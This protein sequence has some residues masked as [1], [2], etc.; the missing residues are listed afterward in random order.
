MQRYLSLFFMLLGINGLSAQSFR[1]VSTG[2][3]YSQQTFFQLGDEEVT[4]LA[5]ETWDLAFT[6]FGLQDAGIH[7]NESAP[8]SSDNAAPGLELYLA[9]SAD[10]ANEI[11][12]EELSQ[13]LYNTEESWINGALNESKNANDPLD[14][15]WGRYNPVNHQIVGDRVFVLKLRDG[16]YKKFMIERLASSTYHLRIADLDGANEITTSVNKNDFTSAGLA[17]FSFTTLSTLAIIPEKWELLFCR[18]TSPLDDGAGGTIAYNLT[19]ILTN[20]G[21]EVA[22]IRDMATDEVDQNVQMAFE[23]RLDIIGSDWKVFDFSSGWILEDSLSY[24]VKTADNQ[25]YKL[26][27]IDFE[28]SGT[29]TATF[30]QYDLGMLSSS[31]SPFTPTVSWSIYPNPVME[32]ELTLSVQV[33]SA[34]ANAQLGLFNTLGQKVWQKPITVQKGLNAWNLALPTTLPSGSYWLTLQMADGQLSKVIYLK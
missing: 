6:A 21:I 11:I 13:R 4:V 33:D 2:N 14:F 18:Y 12:P 20:A 34:I 5:N 30:E 16:R 9:P 31:D 26:V 8:L 27:F 1:Q 7:L 25:L 19:G 32:R 23:S 3:S 29:G 15:G 17:F 24:V 10:F 28:G 22:E